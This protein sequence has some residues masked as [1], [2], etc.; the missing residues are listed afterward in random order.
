LILVSWF[1]LKRFLK[2]SSDY[3]KK[4]IRWVGL[5]SLLLLL[6][7]GKLQIIFVLLTLLPLVARFFPQSHPLRS[8]FKPSSPV[9]NV[10]QPTGNM[11]MKAAYE[12]LGLSTNASRNEILKAHR[13]LM[14]KV[15]PDRG[16]SNYLAAEINRAKEILLNK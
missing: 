15:H 12:V 5:G 10:A 1:L 7:S 4:I 11:T 2:I 13:Q 3:I 8:F 16:G 6:L 9:N 14:Q